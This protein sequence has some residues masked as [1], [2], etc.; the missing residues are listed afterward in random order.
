[1]R[2]NSSSRFAQQ[3]VVTGQST[4]VPSS[5]SGVQ[6]GIAVRTVCRRREV[7]EVAD[8]RHEVRVRVRGKMPLEQRPGGR[9]DEAGAAGGRTVRRKSVTVE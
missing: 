6:L 2:G 3:P 4:P 8:V 1:M 9:E 7:V 5:Q